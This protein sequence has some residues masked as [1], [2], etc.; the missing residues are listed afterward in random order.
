M[1]EENTPIEEENNKIIVDFRPGTKIKETPKEEQPIPQQQETKQKKPRNHKLKVRL[2]G[3]PT[4]IKEES[5]TQ[6]QIKPKRA[7]PKRKQQTEQEIKPVEQPKEEIKDENIK[8]VKLVKCEKCDKAM[9]S[10]TLKYS[11][12]CCE[13]KTTIKKPINKTIEY[14]D[15]PPAE[16]PKQESTKGNFPPYELNPR[17]QRMKEKEKTRLIEN[18]F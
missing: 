3:E 15:E 18:A 4:T 10:K 9:T 1:E 11:H 12:K 17:I 2:E 6:E 5:P 16:K 13:E 14:E 7:P 8:V